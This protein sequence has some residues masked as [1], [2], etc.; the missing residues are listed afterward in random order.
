MLAVTTVLVQ[1]DEPIQGDDGAFYRARVIG[2]ETGL[3]HWEGWIEFRSPEG[4]T[5]ATDRETTQPNRRDLDYWVTGLTRVY[6]QGALRRARDRAFTPPGV[7]AVRKSPVGVPPL[8]PVLDPFAVYAQGEDVLRQ[9]LR[10]LSIDHLRTI[11]DAY[12]LD[13]ALP[14]EREVTA[15]TMDDLGSRIVEVVRA[16][17]IGIAR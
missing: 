4:R 12:G 14:F 17:T 10:A 16:R 9:E 1:F 5:I 6:L 13:V 11:V 2:G 8:S 3:G 7:E 15:A